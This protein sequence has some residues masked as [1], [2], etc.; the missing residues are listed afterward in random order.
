MKI[1]V[2]YIG[3]EREPLVMI[4]D[5]AADPDALRSI[6]ITARFG[7]AAH[8]YPGIRADLPAD[9]P[10]VQV[11]IIADVLRDVFG[12]PG[13]VEV[14][15][16]SYSIVTTQPEDLSVN[17]RLPHCDAFDRGR[18]ALV[19]Y[20]SPDGGDGTAFFR[21][22]STG[23]ET[24]DRSRAVIYTG[25]LDAELRHGGPPPMSYVAAD[26]PLFERTMLA[27]AR[28]NRALIYRSYA[29]HSG[30]IS[31]GASL[32]PDPETGRLTITGFLSIGG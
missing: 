28:Y 3:S 19:H 12:Q 15:D 31:R 17:Q 22:R 24:V 32:S 6:A 29:L 14:I 30:A 21:H 26:T 1:G 10:P 13:A 8:H 4:D 5:F 9:Y 11:P 27:E 7:P 20:L 18:I 2:E 16:A 25:Q 23:F